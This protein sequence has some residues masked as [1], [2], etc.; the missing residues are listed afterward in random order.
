MD[1]DSDEKEKDVSPSHPGQSPTN[2]GKRSW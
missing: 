1:R 2:T